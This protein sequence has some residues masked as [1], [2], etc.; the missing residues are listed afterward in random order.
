MWN[1][2]EENIFNLCDSV[3]RFQEVGL[4]KGEKRVMGVMVSSGIAGFESSA[5]EGHSSSAWDNLHVSGNR[6]RQRPVRG[7]LEPEITRQFA[8]TVTA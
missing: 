4:G 8:R 6:N 7:L 2:Q 1:Q 3:A 5:G